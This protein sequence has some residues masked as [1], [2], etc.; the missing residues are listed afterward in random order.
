M[1]RSDDLFE[2]NDAFFYCAS[3]SYII[4]IF[5]KASCSFRSSLPLSWYREA[6]PNGHSK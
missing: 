4:S 6:D 3:N 2:E 5:F 1:L